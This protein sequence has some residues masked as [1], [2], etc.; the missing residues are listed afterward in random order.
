MKMPPGGF[1]VRFQKKKTRRLYLAEKKR[2]GWEI[3]IPIIP[4]TA[5][6]L[7]PGMDPQDYYEHL[8]N[9]PVF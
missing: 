7:A 9:L 4:E 2:E 6:H 8:F 1:F 5:M 3:A